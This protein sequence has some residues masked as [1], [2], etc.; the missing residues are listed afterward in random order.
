MICEIKTSDNEKWNN[1]DE[2]EKNNKASANW[3]N[4]VK[5]HNGDNSEKINWKGKYEFWNYGCETKS[6]CVG[7]GF[8]VGDMGKKTISEMT[9]DK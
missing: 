9:G 1:N 7:T 6:E 4:Q 2:G 5:T 3:A 8:S